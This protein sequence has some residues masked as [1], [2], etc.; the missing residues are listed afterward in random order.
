MLQEKAY[1][2]VEIP[3]RLIFVSRDKDNQVI[4]FFLGP[5]SEGKLQDALA[6]AHVLLTSGWSRLVRVEIHLYEHWIWN[7]SRKPLAV[8]AKEDL[9]VEE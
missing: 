3:G 5:S 2:N 8:V 7:S 9:A 4:D 6:I 1:M